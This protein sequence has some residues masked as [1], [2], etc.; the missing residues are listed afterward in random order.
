M[1]Q[2]RQIPNTIAHSPAASRTVTVSFFAAALSTWRAAHVAVPEMHADA[3]SL[4]AVV[5]LSIKAVPGARTAL[6]VGTE[7][8]GLPPGILAGSRTV[9][10]PMRAGFDSLNVATAS[11]IALHHLRACAMPPH[12]AGGQRRPGDGP[13]GADPATSAAGQARLP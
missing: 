12:A 7:G 8:A 5:K 4:D 2:R 13:G 11:G 6:L 10:I 3:V 9:A 1:W